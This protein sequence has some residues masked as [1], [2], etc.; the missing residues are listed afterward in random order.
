MSCPWGLHRVVEPAGVLPQRA[1]RL[2]TDPEPG[3]D[4]VVLDVEWLN[5]DAA[6]LRQLREQ[7]VT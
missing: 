7:Y 3:A 2:N 6:S 4:E 1:W 5:L